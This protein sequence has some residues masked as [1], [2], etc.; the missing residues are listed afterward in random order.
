MHKRMTISLTEEVYDG[1]YRTIG[2][3]RMSKFIED[4]LKPHVLGSAL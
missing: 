2:K 1:L 3:R 4:L